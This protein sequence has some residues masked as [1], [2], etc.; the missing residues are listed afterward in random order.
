MKD[1][2]K[3]KQKQKTPI[4]NCQSFL[5]SFKSSQFP[6]SDFTFGQLSIVEATQ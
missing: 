6:S 2:E 3:Q 4:Q 5:L 1:Q